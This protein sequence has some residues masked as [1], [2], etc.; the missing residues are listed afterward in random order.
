VERNLYTDK[1]R[2]R[3][4]YA[5]KK[6]QTNTLFIPIYVDLPLEEGNSEHNQKSISTRDGRHAK[7]K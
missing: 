3:R 7:K 2:K 5:R 6:R 1:R 4:P